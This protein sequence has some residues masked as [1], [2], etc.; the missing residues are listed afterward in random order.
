MRRFKRTIEKSGL[1]EDLRGKEHFEKP[2][3]ARKRKKEAAVK[4][5]NKE[6]RV[7]QLPAKLY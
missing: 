3:T 5:A 7:Q 2:T 6:K 4:R 1:L